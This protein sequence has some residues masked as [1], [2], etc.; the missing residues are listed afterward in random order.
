MKPRFRLTA[1]GADV[2]A[3]F[4]D[5]LLSLTVTDQDGDKADRLGWLGRAVCLTPGPGTGP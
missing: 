1:N 5:R 3:R 2:T 4:G